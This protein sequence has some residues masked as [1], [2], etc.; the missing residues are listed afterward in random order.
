MFK[1][2]KYTLQLFV[3]ALICFP[4]YYFSQIDSLKTQ[5]KICKSDT[6][7]VNIYNAL[8]SKLLHE[9]TPESF[10]YIFKSISLS[11]QINY[12][13]GLAESYFVL[14]NLHSFNSADSSLYYLQKSIEIKAKLKD[15][16]GVASLY[17]S[18]GTSYEK[19]GNSELALNYYLKSLK[20]FDSLHIEK[21]IAGA[22]LGAGNIFVD[23]KNF[24]KAIEYYQKSIDNYKKINSPYLSWAINN[25]ATVY[26][27]L[28]DNK[29]AKTLYEESLKLKLENNDF[30]GAVFSIDD[31]GLILVK[32]GNYKEALTYFFKALKINREKKLEKETF[33]NSYKNIVNVLLLMEDSSKAYTYL[34]FLEAVVRELNI[35]DLKLEF[36]RLKSE[37]YK[38]IKDFE[39]ACIYK[40]KYIEL[41]DSVLTS[42]MHK[43]VAEAESKYQT[44]KKEKENKLLQTQNQLSIA[45][46]K[47][48]KI[49]TYF[50]IGGLLIVSGL[51]FFIFKGLKNQRKANKII[52]L[53]KKEVE[54]QKQKVEEH[55]KEI[56]D[57]IH[58]AKRIQTAL[59]PH[60]KY[61]ER[62]L[63]NLNK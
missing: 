34:G 35:S 24:K 33:A 37:Y 61:I 41:K 47:Q 42:D 20:L 60:E 52:S 56:L 5:L 31:I 11:K 57:S 51:A 7:K 28:N 2:Q 12:Q 38:N 18:I 13:K 32:E 48:Q 55:Q 10:L 22:A 1:A 63:N 23:I 14:G 40:D 16:K 17:I 21:G 50:I 9:N 36:M 29:K 26:S 49:V 19:F 58:Y 46:I 39:N 27:K 3:V 59:L 43:Q 53:Q 6:Q 15:L 8:A 30:Y 44:E 54:H 62:K 4:Y 25:L 45:T